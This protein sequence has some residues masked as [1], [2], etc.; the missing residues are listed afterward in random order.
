MDYSREEALELIKDILDVC[1]PAEPNL[2]KM[3]TEET[4]LLQ[5][6]PE[7]IMMDLDNF[8]NEVEEVL[9][10]TLADSCGQEAITED[11]FSKVSNVIS[12]VCVAMEKMAKD[13]FEEVCEISDSLKLI[14]REDIIET[15]DDDEKYW[16]V[17]SLSSVEF[18]KA[19][20][21]ATERFNKRNE[22]EV[23]ELHAQVPDS[24]KP[25][26]KLL[27][28]AIE[29]NSG[30][31]DLLDIFIQHEYMGVDC[32]EG[33]IIGERL[34]DS[35]YCV[36]AILKLYQKENYV[37]CGV[38]DANK[39][40]E[41]GFEFPS[42]IE[43][44]NDL[45]PSIMMLSCLSTRLLERFSNFYEYSDFEDCTIDYIPEDENLFSLILAIL[46]MIH[47]IGEQCGDYTLPDLIKRIEKYG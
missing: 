16:Q 7:F 14:D 40:F 18:K 17:I 12:A 47:A 13:R 35:L 32:I 22:I 46:S 36:L 31:S 26:L 38:S 25:T 41:L 8:V 37:A 20:E 45:M 11:Y 21:G 39:E 24:V 28:Y 5:E 9:G 15:I 29:F 4:D 34:M 27:G 30:C 3:V 42:D 19:I 23:G 6:I 2:S 44:L 10:S 1:I 33:D 43:N